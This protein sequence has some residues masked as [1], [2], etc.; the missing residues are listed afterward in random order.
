MDPFIEEG[1]LLKM[2]EIPASYV[3]LPEDRLDVPQS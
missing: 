2:G 3:I 1:F